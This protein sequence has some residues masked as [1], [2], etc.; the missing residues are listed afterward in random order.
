MNDLVSLMVQISKRF[1]EDLQRINDFQS[2]NGR[3]NLILNPC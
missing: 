1:L 3:M 2:I